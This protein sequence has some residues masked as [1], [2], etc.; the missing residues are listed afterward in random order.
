MQQ[1]YSK[2]RQA[3]RNQIGSGIILLPGNNNVPMNYPS[4][5]LPFRQDS[6]LLYFTG[7]DKPGIFFIMDCDSDEE[8]IFGN[9]PDTDDIIWTGPQ[10]AIAA[11]AEAVGIIKTMPFSHLQSFLTMKIKKGRK[12]LY[13]PPY[14]SDRKILLSNLLNKSLDEIEKNTSID[15]IKAIVKLRSYKSPEEINEIET[16]LDNATGPFHTENLKV[17]K[18]GKY[19]YDVVANMRKIVQENNLSFA[20]PIICTVH[21]EILH[22]EEYHHQLKSG[23][24]L[25]VDAAA[26]SSLHYASDITRTFPVNGKFQTQQKEI[27]ELVLSTQLG[28]IEMMK[29]GVRFIDIHKTA[30]KNIITGLQNLGL[31]KGNVDEALDQGAH[32]LFFPHGLGHMLGLD[33]HDMEDLGENYVGYNENIKRSD[34]FGTAYVRCA[35][36]LEPGFVLTV[37]PGIYFIPIL[38]DRWY[39]EKKYSQF[40]NYENVLRYKNFGGI[41]IEDDVAITQTGHQVLGKHIPKTV[42][43][44]EDIM[45]I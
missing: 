23:Q 45:N 37:E 14:P 28:S 29:P 36:E 25:L 11:L 35:R 22:N 5:P 40:I 34:Q 10:K 2:R 44:I 20:F 38:I 33:V 18:P 7:I 32:A 21:G 30:A 39:S 13:L 42:N 17:A 8:I 31:M 15:L 12:L 1:E 24:L 3:L 26:E 19:E 27:Y 41:R 6:S 4:N 16:V 43:E 9:D